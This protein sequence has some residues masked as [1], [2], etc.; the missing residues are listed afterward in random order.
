MDQGKTP[1][2]HGSH[3]VDFLRSFLDHEVVGITVAT[4]LLVLLA[5]LLSYMIFPRDSPSGLSFS[6]RLAI[7]MIYIQYLEFNH[8]VVHHGEAKNDKDRPA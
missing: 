4:G 5:Y 1:V 8:R 6:V 7:G 3:F 2:T